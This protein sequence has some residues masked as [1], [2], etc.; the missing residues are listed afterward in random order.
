MNYLRVR[1]ASITGE[2]AAVVVLEL[3]PVAGGIA[4]PGA[5]AGAHIDLHLA[6]GLAR[7]YSLL[8]PGEAPRR[9]RIAVGLDA[10]SRGGS[11]FVHERLRAAD[12]IAISAPRNN[13]PLAEDASHSILIAGGI[14]ITPL[15]AMAKRLHALGKSWQLHYCAR[16]R[17][18]AAFVKELEAFGAAVAFNFDHEPGGRLLD[19]PRV[20][21]AAPAATHFY[22]CGPALM[23]QA[24]ERATA[25]LAPAVV[26]KE[27]FS[28]SGGK[29]TGG[30]SVALAKT[31]RSFAVPEGR[32]ILDV[33]MDAGI[34]VTH[35]CTEGVCGSC[36]TRVLE[37]VPDHRDLILS[38]EEKQA[39]KTMMI[40]CSG[41]RTDRLVLDL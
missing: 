24:F 30:F 12:E 28:G 2:A 37:G 11:K 22:C 9:Y 19:I 4:L 10:A 38:D 25:A 29:A 35:S 40:C 16:T 8:D 36:E 23:M 17:T 1:I 3:Q 41:S 13:F 7:S 32:S 21:A 34:E 5:A 6:N 18:D 33:L 27:Y 26:H 39:G 20:I 15:Q 14:G 31:G